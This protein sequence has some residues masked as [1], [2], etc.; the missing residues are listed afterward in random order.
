MFE[1]LF[2]VYIYVSLLFYLR[3]NWAS[4]LY[5][6]LTHNILFI[7]LP[8]YSSSLLIIPVLD[9]KAL[10]GILSPGTF[11]QEL[12]MADAVEGRDLAMETLLGWPVLFPII[13]FMWTF[14]QMLDAEDAAKEQ[15]LIPLLLELEFYF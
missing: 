6:P 13:Y 8:L 5:S 10:F 4:V 15:D 9:L 14:Y 2:N 7:L 3:S 1:T 12:K 11:I